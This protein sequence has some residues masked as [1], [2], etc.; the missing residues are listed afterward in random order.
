MIINLTQHLATHEQLEAGVIDLEYNTSLKLKKLITF[1]TLP[2]QHDL[3]ERAKFVAMLA[4][5]TGAKKAMIGG[6]PFFMSHLEK[7]LKEQGITPYYAFSERVCSEKFKDGKI[8]KV[9]EFK[10]LGFIM[11]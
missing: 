3:S 11:A 7:A 5:S 8:I 2:S 4:H 10:H 9:N 6:A 1:D